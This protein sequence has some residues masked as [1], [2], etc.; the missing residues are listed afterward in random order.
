MKR[1]GGRTERSSPCGPSRPRTQPDSSRLN[2]KRRSASEKPAVFVT[3]QNA[4]G[5]AAM[6]PLQAVTYT[7]THTY[8][9]TG[10]SSRKQSPVSLRR[11]SRRLRV[12]H[13]MQMS[14]LIGCAVLSDDLASCK[15]GS[16]E[17]QANCCPAAHFHSVF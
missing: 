2:W 13:C 8:T 3:S 6:A 12:S 16:K 5:E 4:L 15:S 11:T 10:I 1:G 17:V 14:I 7:H 9:H